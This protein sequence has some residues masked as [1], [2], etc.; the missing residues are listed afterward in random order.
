VRTNVGYITPI[1]LSTPWDITT[2]V[3]DTAN[4]L[5]SC[6]FAPLLIGTNG[7]IY[8]VN[9]NVYVESDR[10]TAQIPLQTANVFS[11]V[12]FNKVKGLYS[13]DYNGGAGQS[14]GVGKGVHVSPDG[15]KMFITGDSS[16]NRT[17][18]F[19]LSIPY[20]ITTAVYNSN[21]V[22]TTS[23]VGSD[24]YFKPDGTKMYL[25]SIATDRITEYSLS[26]P[27][28]VD[29]AAIVGNIA[30]S[31]NP[32]G[33]TFKPDGTKMYVVKTSNDTINEFN[34]ST[35]WQV[36]T[37]VQTSSVSVS[38][39]AFGGEG[40][41]AGIDISDNGLFI[42]VIGSDRDAIHQY[43]LSTPW[44]ANTATYNG[45]TS[46]S[47]KEQTPSGINFTKDGYYF[48]FIGETQSYVW[49]YE[50]GFLS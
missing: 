34:L 9:G 26:T 37:A 5:S 11:N 44:Q 29:T 12:D 27:W 15:T 16:V 36:N 25:P 6:L 32:T 47:D 24:L 33:I 48:Y 2:S 43:N 23:G 7:G 46:I 14:I 39:F 19:N 20:D 17:Y 45:N 42:Y 30:I 10:L 3:S 41:P 28:Q 22:H 8:S 31:L 40:N 35:P 38:A 4:N 49:Q 50:I 18:Q 1:K 13:V 21:L